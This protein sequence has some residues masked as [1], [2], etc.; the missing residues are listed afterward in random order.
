MLFNTTRRA[1]RMVPTPKHGGRYRYGRGPGRIGAFMATLDSPVFSMT[2]PQVKKAA[3]TLEQAWLRR[4]ERKAARTLEQAWLRQKERRWQRALVHMRRAWACRPALQRS[5]SKIREALSQC[6][7]EDLAAHIELQGAV[8]TLTR[9]ARSLVDFPRH[10][11]RGRSVS[12]RSSA[13]AAASGR[14]RR[15]SAMAAVSS[16]RSC[17]RF[18]SG[19]DLAYAPARVR[20]CSWTC[21][22][23]VSRLPAHRGERR[24]TIKS[25]ITVSHTATHMR[26]YSTGQ[27]TNQFR[28]HSDPAKLTVAK[29]GHHRREP[30]RLL[31]HTFLNC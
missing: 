4:K 27:S 14:S 30:S 2:E 7:G 12:S 24:N 18:G 19:R 23:P 8:V 11:T 1:P 22:R 26:K 25:E 5:P 20:P 9:R 28:L 10:A 21:A 3:R 13:S 17:G 29:H 16:M 31:R 15:S 6:F